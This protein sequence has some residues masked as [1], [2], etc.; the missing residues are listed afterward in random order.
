MRRKRV[1]FFLM[2]PLALAVFAFGWHLFKK[3]K[4]AS[5]TEIAVR[6]QL[7]RQPASATGAAVA[8]CQA[9]EYAGRGPG[10]SGIASK[11]W[12]VF[13]DAYHELKG[14]YQSWLDSRRAELGNKTWTAMSTRMKDLRIQR[15]PTPGEPDLAWR[16]IGVLS[17][18]MAGDPI[19]RL[20]D[21]YFKL[22][23]KNPSR[24]RF[25]LARLMAQVWAPC[26]LQKSKIEQP[27]AELAQCLGM[28]SPLKSCGEG[29]FSDAGWA[30]S[31]ALATLVSKPGCQLPA[32][33]S[34]QAQACVWRFPI[35]KGWKEARR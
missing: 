29:Q 12:R 15:P 22:Y 11:E 17:Y 9:I 1:G 6:A 10:H 7:E 32:F 31:S 33:A 18:D 20:G 35:A 19:V 26:E 21:G 16:G 4:P 8:E 14:S 28:E 5:D 23:R 30:V 24:A 27:W 2:V 3:A 25:E 13:M 34:P